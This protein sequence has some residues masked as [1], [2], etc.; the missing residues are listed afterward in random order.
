[1]VVKDICINKVIMMMTL[2][3]TNKGKCIHE[4]VS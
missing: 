1:M 4:S 3:E 2:Q